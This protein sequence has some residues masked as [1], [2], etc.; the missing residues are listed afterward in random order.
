NNNW[1][2]LLEKPRKEPEDPEEE[3]ED[4]QEKLDIDT[5]EPANCLNINSDTEPILAKWSNWLRS[6]S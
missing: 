6:D 5:D 2:K 4:L 1:L 3:L